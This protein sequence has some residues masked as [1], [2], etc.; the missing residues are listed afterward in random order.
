M[1]SLR[2]KSHI[3]L[4]GIGGAGLSAIAR[5]LLEKGY[6]VSGSDQQI[7]AIAEVLQESG[8]RVFV[9]HHPRNVNGADLVI[10]SSAI[11]DDN[12]EVQESI[13]MGIQVLKRSE[14]LGSLIGDQRT[15]AVAGSHGKTTTTAMISWMLTQLG[16]DPSYIIGGHS[17]DLGKNAHAGQ[18]RDFVI[19]ADEYDRMFLGLRPWIAVVTNVE[20]DHP[21]CFPTEEDFRHV[22]REFVDRIVPDG[23]LIFC[24]DDRG[25]AHLAIKARENHLKAISYGLNQNST[26]YPL[27]YM[28]S[29]LK[30]KEG[31]TYTFKVV[32]YG[33]PKT[34]VV[35]QIPGRHNVYNALAALAVAGTRGLDMMKAAEAIGSFS[36]TR[37]RFE[38]LG[39]VKGITIIDDY[40][41]HPS[42][43]RATLSAARQRYPNRQIWAV[44]Q[45]HTFSRTRLLQ[46]DFATAFEEAE[47]VLVTEIYAAREADPGNFS[48]KQV[49]EAMN[50]PDV[51]F[52][53]DFE[54]AVEIL[55]SGLEDGQVLIVLSAGNATEISIQVMKTLSHEGSAE[56]VH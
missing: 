56:H 19:E 18:G 21:D 27:D 40:A 6:H 22:F 20:H 17:K 45:P 48:A 31:G 46:D 29:N 1:V 34:E 39:E 42:E 3:H 30:L 8:I 14:F 7:S 44:W 33:L 10:R 12:I 38:V 13:R 32:H 28:T 23:S 16:E 15:I 2:P 51:H 25:S 35:M 37:R 55:V 24:G 11:P 49:V 50:H 47:H 52:V 26:G 4:I 36:G 5:V 9:G 41:H 53:P 54:Q 43:I